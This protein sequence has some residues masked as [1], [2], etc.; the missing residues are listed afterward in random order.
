LIDGLSGFG[1]S[2]KFCWDFSFG[3]AW[4]EEEGSFDH[5]WRW[6]TARKGRVGFEVRA[7]MAVSARACESRTHMS[8]DGHG[9][10][11]PHAGPSGG[12]SAGF[13]AL[14]RASSQ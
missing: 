9:G 14:A 6:G 1:N 4:D 3:V 13:G 10:A 7:I 11:E 2:G 8:L 12:R 5:I